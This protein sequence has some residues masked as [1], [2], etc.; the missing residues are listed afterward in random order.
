MVKTETC[1]IPKST[2]PQL[3]TYKVPDYPKSTELEKT[4]CAVTTAPLVTMQSAYIFHAMTTFGFN[5]QIFTQF[6][7]YF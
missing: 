7:G 2:W 6:T 4:Y 5:V 1:K 3:Q